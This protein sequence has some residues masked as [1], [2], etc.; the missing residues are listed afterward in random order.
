MLYHIFDLPLFLGI[1]PTWICQ[2]TK[3]EIPWVQYRENVWSVLK[4]KAQWK[5]PRCRDE[6]K[7]SLWF[8]DFCSVCHCKSAQKWGRLLGGLCGH[9]CVLLLW[10]PQCF[11][12]ILAWI[13]F[14]LLPPPATHSLF[15]TSPC[16][17]PLQ[18]CFGMCFYRWACGFLLLCLAFSFIYCKST[19]VSLAGLVDCCCPCL[20]FPFI[21]CK[22]LKVPWAP[23]SASLPVLT[24]PGIWVPEETLTGESWECFQV[25]NAT[26]ISKNC[27]IKHFQ[28]VL[29]ASWRNQVSW[30]LFA[31]SALPSAL[32]KNSILFLEASDCIAG[33]KMLSLL[34]VLMSLSYPLKWK[35]CNWTWNL[36]WSSFLQ[37]VKLVLEFPINNN[38]DLDFRNSRQ[39]KY[40]L[41]CVPLIIM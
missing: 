16:H 39:R 18:F 10:I 31:Y 28:M 21:Y 3:W 25:F 32:I 23:S 7:G 12:L 30:S 41:K 36:N 40:Y 15:Q 9:F 17:V 35:K 20:A 37:C 4:G 5:L 14:A 2:N 38:L 34:L 29:F 6:D 26:L 11:T 19:K 24:V 13:P 27:L 33:A 8:W 22:S 1:P